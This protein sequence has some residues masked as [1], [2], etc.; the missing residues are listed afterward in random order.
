MQADITIFCDQL[1]VQ[2]A[3]G[4]TD[5]MDKMRTD[6]LLCSLMIKRLEQRPDLSTEEIIREYFWFNDH[7]ERQIQ[8]MA[9]FIDQHYSRYSEKYTAYLNKKLMYFPD[10]PNI[11]KMLSSTVA[12]GDIWHIIGNVVFFLAFAPA[13][14]LLLARAWMFMGVIVVMAI[15]TSL[16]YTA[17][18]MLG[19]EALPALGLSG[20]VMGMIGMTA[21]LIPTEKIKVFVWLLTYIRNVYIP[22]WILALWYIGVDLLDLLLGTG[23]PGI[24][25]IAHVTGGVTGYLLGVFYFK[26][27]LQSVTTDSTG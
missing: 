13:I 9:D 15:T 25:L 18:V 3:V 8:K 20:V 19:A 11:L 23:D 12:H 1:S 24:N 2:A 14:E 7:S 27:R 16:S 17:S 22:A 26:K 5:A 21:A 4:T 6:K 10:T